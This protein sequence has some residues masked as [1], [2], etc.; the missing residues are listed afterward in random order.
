MQRAAKATSTSTATATC[1]CDNKKKEEGSRIQF[2]ECVCVA[3]DTRKVM[4]YFLSL[5]VVEE[6]QTHVVVA[7]ALLV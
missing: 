1:V 7:H 3:A 4:A 2:I 6:K 5:V